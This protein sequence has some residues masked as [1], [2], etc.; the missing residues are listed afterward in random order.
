MKKSHFFQ[1]VLFSFF[2]CIMS[3]SPEAK[4][5][6]ISIAQMPVYA[7]NTEKGVLVDL[8]KAMCKESGVELELQVVPFKRSMDDVITN[9]V[10]FHMPLIHNPLIDEATLPY[11]HST[12]TIFHVNFTLY[13]NKNKPL[14]KN[15]LKNYK[16]ETDAAH[17][18]YFPFSVI[19]STDLEGSIK[20]VDA[21][22]IDGFIFADNAIDPLIKKLS[23]KNV[24]REL[25][26]RFD[27]KI[28][29]P[30][31]DKSKDTD[32]YIT[33]TIGT[34][35]TQGIYASIMN[36]LDQPFAP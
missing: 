13:T 3:I 4:K 14:D 34:L 36:A 10:D 23:L 31:N 25:Y 1:M 29:L 30:K 24:N 15:S 16:I 20:K 17:V 21:G 32:L 8:A 12:E 2:L 5:I 18:Q 6:K 22:R 28:I 27:V 33:K 11:K 26:Q 7:E 35:R 9:K 19:S